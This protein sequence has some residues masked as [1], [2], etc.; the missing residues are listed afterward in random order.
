MKRRLQITFLS[1][2]SHLRELRVNEGCAQLTVSV[3]IFPYLIYL[4]SV[5]Q[6]RKDQNA[7]PPDYTLWPTVV[8]G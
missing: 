2:P 7:T 1:R 6:V 5:F 3:D 8:M 4:C